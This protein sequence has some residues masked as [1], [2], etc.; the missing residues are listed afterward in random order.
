MH[1]NEQSDSPPPN[2]NSDQ[3]DALR[4]LG[5]TEAQ[6]I[7]LTEALP[8]CAVYLIKPAPR[9]HVRDELDDLRVNIENAQEVVTRLRNPRT[10]AAREALAR[11]NDASFWNGDSAFPGAELVQAAEAL[12]TL[13]SVTIGASVRLPNKPSRFA[14][15]RPE[16]VRRIYQALLTGWTDEH[17]ALPVLHTL[18]DHRTWPPPFRF[19]PSSNLTSPFRDIV[20]ICYTAFLGE[21][22]VDPERAIRDFVK[23][24]RVA[25]NQRRGVS[26]LSLGQNRPQNS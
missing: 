20:G 5:V 9:N 1:K 25:A 24:E 6:I 10:P 2:F 13:K 3:L 22:E 14:K 15:A 16:P 17:P 19:R 12:N 21:H 4:A 18:L 8:D 23:S 26:L 7:R 11:I